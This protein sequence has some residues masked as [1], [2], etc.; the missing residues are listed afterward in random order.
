ML[1]IWMVLCLRRIEGK[2]GLEFLEWRIYPDKNTLYI[3]HESFEKSCFSA[4]TSGF[5]VTLSTALQMSKVATFLLCTEVVFRS[6][7]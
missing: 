4:C 6:L 5:V 2:L 1:S 3:V 7:E